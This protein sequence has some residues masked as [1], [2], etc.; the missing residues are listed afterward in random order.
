MFPFTYLKGWT[1][2]VLQLWKLHGT[3]PCRN[4]LCNRLL[5]L[6][7]GAVAPAIVTFEVR[8]TR[9]HMQKEEMAG[10]NTQKEGKVIQSSGAAPILQGV[11]SLLLW[12]TRYL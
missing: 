5:N 9:V 12:V 7:F 1:N 10:D 2:L 11:R 8:V 4:I 6:C 3:V